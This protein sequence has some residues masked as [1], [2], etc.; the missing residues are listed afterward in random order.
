ML[1][2]LT[3]LRGDK[4]TSVQVALHVVQSA[5]LYACPY[6]GLKCFS[7]N[8]LPKLCIKNKY[9][10]VD[11]NLISE[12]LPAIKIPTLVQTLIKRVLM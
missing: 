3:S 6:L 7:I 12:N 11:E 4:Y 10:A 5:G 1:E 8:H 2:F 9:T